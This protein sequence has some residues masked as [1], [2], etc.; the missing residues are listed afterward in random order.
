MN[1]KGQNRGVRSPDS[2]LGR[3]ELIY[4]ESKDLTPSPDNF[5]VFDISHRPY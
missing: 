5:S 1:L 4:V 3:V 2:R